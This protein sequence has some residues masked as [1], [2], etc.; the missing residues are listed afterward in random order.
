V[1]SLRLQ[2]LS[3]NRGD[4][5]SSPVELPHQRNPLSSNTVLLG[6][7][8]DIMGLFTPRATGIGASDPVLTRLV[9]EDKSHWWNKP[10]LRYLYFMLFWSCMG[11]EMTSGFDSQMIN[12]LQIVPSWVEYFDDPQGSRKGIIAAAY[13]LGAI[14]SL[15][16]IPLVVERFGRRWGIFGGSWVMVG[17]AII[18]C[19][20]QNSTSTIEPSN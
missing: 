12:A 6:R 17:G 7:I 19:F 18:Q 16:F 1:L 2:R 3:I 14:I 8:T 20:A 13:A 11:I 4:C 5:K 15:P 9:N 10:N